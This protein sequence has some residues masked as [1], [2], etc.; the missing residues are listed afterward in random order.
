MLRRSLNAVH[1]VKKDTGIKKK[2]TNHLA[3]SFLQT[4]FKSCCHKNQI[5]NFVRF[6]SSYCKMVNKS[7][8][9]NNNVNER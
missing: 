4:V 7:F 2:K 1:A 5:G 8:A 9:Y 3:F 6:M